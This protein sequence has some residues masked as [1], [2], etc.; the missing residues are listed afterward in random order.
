M[1]VKVITGVGWRDMCASV[2]VSIPVVISLPPSLGI[3]KWSSCLSLYSPLPSSLY[4]F[5]L[6]L[7]VTEVSL[8]VVSILEQ[9]GLWQL[10]YRVLLYRGK[11]W[12]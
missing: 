6:Q 10:R 7:R 11:H 12:L 9:C 8:G 3:P 5:S 2:S 4:S 1:Y